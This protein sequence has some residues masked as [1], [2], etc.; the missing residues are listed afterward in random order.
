MGFDI[1]EINLVS[2]VVFPITLHLRGDKKKLMTLSFLQ[3]L[4]FEKTKCPYFFDLWP[5]TEI[6][7]ISSTYDSSNLTPRASNEE[8]VISR[9]QGLKSKN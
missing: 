8:M 1:I 4:K 9:L 5:G 7:A 6:L 2:S 3:L